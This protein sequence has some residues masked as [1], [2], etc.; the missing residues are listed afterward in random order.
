MDIKLS[1][2]I[3]VLNGLESYFKNLEV[4]LQQTDI[5]KFTRLEQDLEKSKEYRKKLEN[6]KLDDNGLFQAVHLYLS[7]SNLLEN[8]YKDLEFEIPIGEEISKTRAYKLT[9][10]FDNITKIYRTYIKDLLKDSEAIINNASKL[11]KTKNPLELQ[12]Y[13][14]QWPNSIDLYTMLQTEIL[15]QSI[16]EKNNTLTSEILEIIE[17]DKQ[18]ILNEPQWISPFLTFNCVPWKSTPLP[19]SKATLDNLINYKNDGQIIIDRSQKSFVHLLPKSIKWGPGITIEDISQTLIPIDGKY[20]WKIDVINKDSKK[21][22]IIEKCGEQYR[23]LVPWKYPKPDLSDDLLIRKIKEHAFGR[24][25]AYHYN[26]EQPLRHVLSK[27]VSILAKE[28]AR[29]QDISLSVLRVTNSLL[30]DIKKSKGNIFNRLNS[31]RLDKIFEND[32]LEELS[33]HEITL[34]DA[35]VYWTDWTRKAFRRDLDNIIN[36]MRDELNVEWD[37]VLEQKVEKILHTAVESQLRKSEIF[38]DLFDK[39][40]KLDTIKLHTV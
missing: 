33:H 25:N 18:F 14:Q 34:L 21:F 40:H 19:V 7:M 29:E 30:D 20:S 36:R 17:K 22:Y 38:Q 1:K 13:W 24:P 10:V 15:N 9:E 3:D 4:Y 27:R 23:I 28:T 35:V 31:D 11:V 2:A 37:V 5:N 8:L 26:L 6:I 16:R 32:I 39:Q 12:K